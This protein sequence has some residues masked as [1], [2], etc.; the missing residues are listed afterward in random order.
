[1]QRG[2][3]HGRILIQPRPHWFFA[4]II[5]AMEEHSHATRAVAPVALKQDAT[6]DF[7]QRARNEDGG[8][9]VK[10][11]FHFREDK[12]ISSERTKNIWW[13]SMLLH[14][15]F[16]LRVF[17]TAT[18]FRFRNLVAFLR[19]RYDKRKLKFNMVNF[20]IYQ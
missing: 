1:M 10:T 9:K 11:Y 17:K 8:E 14:L 16:P 4:R 13:R 18:R 7:R 20:R 12:F 6:D 3:L 5:L 2:G 19:G 15:Y